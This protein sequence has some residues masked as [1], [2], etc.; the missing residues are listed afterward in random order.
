M[1]QNSKPTHQTMHFGKSLW[2]QQRRRRQH[3]SRS[4]FCS[5]VSKFRCSCLRQAFLWQRWLVVWE[6][7]HLDMSK[8]TSFIFKKRLNWALRI[9]NVLSRIL[10]VVWA[11]F[12]SSR[13][14]KHK[15]SPTGWQLLKQTCFKW[16]NSVGVRVSDLSS[17]KLMISLF[18]P[19]LR[20]MIKYNN[21][22][23]SINNLCKLVKIIS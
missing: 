12:W 23:N 20:K 6:S 18:L 5:N 8:S 3:S 2:L 19:F 13:P 7:V 17:A 21:T 14:L 9:W 4:L 11:Y 15:C 16:S 22:T 10:K 1:W